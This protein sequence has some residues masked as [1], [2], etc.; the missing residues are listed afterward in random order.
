MLHIS[1][2]YQM[3]Q[4]SIGLNRSSVYRQYIKAYLVQ[5]HAYTRGPPY[6]QQE[7]FKILTDGLGGKAQNALPPGV[8]PHPN[9]LQFPEQQVSIVIKQ[10][11]V[12][13]KTPCHISNAIYGP[14]LAN[15]LSDKEKWP[16]SVFQS[17]A[18]DSFS[19][20]FN[21]LATSHLSITIK[22][23]IDVGAPIIN[24][25]MIEANI[26]NAVVAMMIKRSVMS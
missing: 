22:T 6:S 18:W 26:K 9:C 25:Y 12:T 13:S 8:K 7:E 15:Y 21:K 10:R 16:P 3:R 24:T 11:T 4:W 1:D 23:C 20:T 19:I 14:E 2:Y 17:I 5:G